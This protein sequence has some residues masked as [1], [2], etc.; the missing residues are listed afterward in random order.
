[1]TQTTKSA[2]PWTE[3]EDKW[4]WK[5]YPDYRQLQL[6]LPCRSLAAIKHRS[7]KLKIV[8]RRHVWTN[9]EVKTLYQACAINATADELLKLF[10]QLSLCQIK[11]KARHIGAARRKFRPVP[12]QDSTL[13]TIRQ[14]AYE[15]GITFVKLDEIAG[16]GR[17]FQKSCREPILRFMTLGIIALG[18]EPAVDWCC[19]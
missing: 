2:A 8:T 5:L 4:V 10:P 7:A 9:R 11:S 12:V 19:S 17:Y 14:K 15:K 3:A 6:K 13:F 16:T 1:M 18:G